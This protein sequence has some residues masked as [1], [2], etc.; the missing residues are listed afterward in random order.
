MRADSS[1]LH[2]RSDNILNTRRFRSHF[3]SRSGEIRKW[4]SQ[5]SSQL[6]H[7]FARRHSPSH[8][9]IHRLTTAHCVLHLFLIRLAFYMFV[10]RVISHNRNNDWGHSLN[11]NNSI[12][13]RN[14]AAFPRIPRV[15][16]HLLVDATKTLNASRVETHLIRPT[17]MPNLSAYYFITR[18]KN[19]KRAN[20]SGCA[21][22]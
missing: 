11:V 9:H 3:S 21:G 7:F 6:A 19:N 22:W 5:T 18:K 16:F 13:C 10:E 17:A 2:T 8:S 14:I 20:E 12:L 15:D 1:Q 4:E